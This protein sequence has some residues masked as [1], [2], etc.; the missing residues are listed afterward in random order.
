MIY[1]PWQPR[2]CDPAPSDHIC[3]QD[4]VY[5]PK[6][7]VIHFPQTPPYFHYQSRTCRCRYYIYSPSKK[8]LLRRLW[9]LVPQFMFIR[10]LSYAWNMKVQIVYHDLQG[11]SIVETIFGKSRTSACH[12][13]QYNHSF[14]SFMHHSW[15]MRSRWKW[16]HCPVKC[17]VSKFELSMKKS[18]VLTE[19]R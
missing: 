5:L 2:D 8:R 6:N 7:N 15:L 13:T 18:R 12:I 17:I 3:H 1:L 4:S 19:S 16:G 10:H 9:Y 14:G 11:S